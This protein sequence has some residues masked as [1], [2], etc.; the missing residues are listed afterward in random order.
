M[1][2]QKHVK[3]FDERR[4]IAIPG[5]HQTTLQFCVDHFLTV[6]AES[7]ADHGY[8]A[9]ALSGGST[10]KEIYKRLAMPD[11]RKRLD[12]SHVKVFW[13]DERYVPI[14]DPQSNYRMAM[15]NGIGQL[16]IPKNNIFSAPTGKD[17]EKDAKTYEDI[18]LSKIPSG[19]FDLVMLGMG[20]DGHTAS[21]FPKTHGLHP[22]ERL[23]I[24]N[25]IPQ[26]DCWRITF[27]FDCINSANHIAIYVLGA[28][29]AEML[30]RVLT[31]PYNSDILPIQRVGT[32]EHKALWIVDSD[33][34]RLLTF[35]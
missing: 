2:W 32:V 17:P 22:N 16:P 13:S 14:D 4:D 26:K 18:I 8:F 10:P 24:A 23:V 9:V 11:N 19:T 25:F 33:A 34:A 15:E 27:T 6:G 29:K 7:V 28:S 35:T 21:L 5:D 1:N 20:E 30:K 3:N 31:G 12:W